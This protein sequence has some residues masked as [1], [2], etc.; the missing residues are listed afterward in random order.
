MKY[1]SQ[2]KSYEKLYPGG[3]PKVRPSI[4]KKSFWHF[5]LQYL[6]ILKWWKYFFSVI[7]DRDLRKFRYDKNIFFGNFLP[8]I[9]ANSKNDF[10][11]FFA[12]SRKTRDIF[13]NEFFPVLCRGVT[14]NISLEKLKKHRKTRQCTTFHTYFWAREIF[15][16]K[17]PQLSKTPKN[18]TITPSSWPRGV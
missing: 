7:K 11:G 9:T 8:L 18:R 1:L 4:R 10:D 15:Y 12:F 3:I 14:C 16:V 2:K 17:R 13:L 6:L 5:E